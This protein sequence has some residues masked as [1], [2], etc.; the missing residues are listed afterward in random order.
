M[1]GNYNVMISGEDHWKNKVLL[2]HGYG[3]SASSEG[4]MHMLPAYTYMKFQAFAIDMPGFG[5]SP[6]TRLSSRNEAILKQ[7]GPADIVL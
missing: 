4:F 5:K 6:G 2:L 7:G 1:I 3:G